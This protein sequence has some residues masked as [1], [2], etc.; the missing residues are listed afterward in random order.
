MNGLLIGMTSSFTSHAEST[1]SLVGF[2]EQSVFTIPASTS[3]TTP[4][5]SQSNTYE[6]VYVGALRAKLFSYGVTPTASQLAS[7]PVST[8]FH[9]IVIN[10]TGRSASTSA[11]GTTADAMSAVQYNDIYTTQ[12][13][14]TNSTTAQSVPTYSVYTVSLYDDTLMLTE[15]RNISTVLNDIRT[16]TYDAVQEIIRASVN[17]H[18][19]SENALQVL[20]SIYNEELKLYNFLNSTNFY[21]EKFPASVPV[22]FSPYS[23]VKYSDYTITPR[24]LRSSG[25]Y[26]YYAIDFDISGPV[27]DV[28][29]SVPGIYSLSFNFSGQ[30]DHLFSSIYDVVVYEADIGG[31][32]LRSNYSSSISPLSANLSFSSGVNSSSLHMAFQYYPLH[33]GYECYGFSFTVYIVC[34]STNLSF[35][36]SGSNNYR[37][38][39]SE[40]VIAD[41]SYSDI[42]SSTQVMQQNASA[43]SSAAKELE[44]VTDTTEYFNQVNTF[45]DNIDSDP[46]KD[47]MNAASLFTSTITA[48]WTSLDEFNIPLNLF[49]AVTLLSV[50]LGVYGRLKGG[51]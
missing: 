34:S 15:V 26:D 8:L 4:A 35:M 5:T 22:N 19:D 44:S 23:L 46:L 39:A 32:D 37:L 20:T 24:L 38:Y 2:S 47:Y 3:S 29:L 12:V 49:L 31:K 51:E 21:M 14:S 42:S 6:V 30:L 41:L 9:Y 25:G 10:R 27:F 11:S 45:I 28:P 50:M 18:T 13:L 48:I 17:A 33:L 16:Y 36:S 40:S 7:T 1:V 43:I